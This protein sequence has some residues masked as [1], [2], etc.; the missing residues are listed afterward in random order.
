MEY[1]RFGDAYVVR[2][3]P[4][5]EVLTQLTCLAEKEQLRL[6]EISGLG[7]LKELCVCVFDV[8]EKVFYDN[9][10]P[11][12]LELLSLSGTI[13]EKDGA[14][15]LHI[16]AAAGD[17]SGRAVGGHLKKAVISATGEIIVRVIDGSV[18]RRFHEGI[19][20]NLFSFS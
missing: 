17:T 10:Y 5:E 14:P 11:G 18:G 9:S 1:R 2:L 12:P 7:A 3:D 15:Y 4:D 13:T 8:A 6:A 20:L 19:G 16:H